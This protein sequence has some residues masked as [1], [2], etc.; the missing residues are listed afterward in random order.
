MRELIGLQ[1][2]SVA[3]CWQR[4]INRALKL[5]GLTQR[6]YAV[7]DGISRLSP[8]CECVT[9]VALAEITYGDSM[10]TST[11]VRGLEKRG[12]VS[13]GA[14]PTDARAHSLELTTKGKALLGATRDLVEAVDED[15]FGDKIVS[16]LAGP[17]AALLR[18]ERLQ[19]S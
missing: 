10:T 11:V 8:D 1:I 16:D 18:S 5:H 17:L 9:Q 2:T 14:H 13:R 3:L 12:L 4:R 19:S 6:Q 7:L 15:M